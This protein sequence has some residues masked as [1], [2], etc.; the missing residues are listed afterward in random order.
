MEED[1]SVVRSERHAVLVAGGRPSSRL[2]NR[3]K[4]LSTT[5]GCCSLLLGHIIMPVQIVY[6]EFEKKKTIGDDDAW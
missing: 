6:S 1:Y 5:T 4:I 3:A 2:W